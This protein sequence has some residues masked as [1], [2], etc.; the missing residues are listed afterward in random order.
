M[1][2][3][4]VDHNQT[5]HTCLFCGTMKREFIPTLDL[6]KPLKADTCKGGYEI[7]DAKSQCCENWVDGREYNVKKKEDKHG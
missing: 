2:I 7:T 5:F 6:D 1:P 3:V 4:K